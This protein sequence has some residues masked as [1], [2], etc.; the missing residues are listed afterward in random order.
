[1]AVPEESESAVGRNLQML[2]RGVGSL[3]ADARRRRVH[4]VCVREAGQPKIS[5]GS[6]NLL[7]QK[8]AIGLNVAESG[9][10][11]AVTG[12]LLKPTDKTSAETWSGFVTDRAVSGLTNGLSFSV[13][14]SMTFGLN[15]FAGSKTLPSPRRRGI[16]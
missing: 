13:L 15:K 11:G 8:S 12:A 6:E 4:K 14:T 2:G 9:I 7:L 5:S 3:S 16:S 1:M 10:A